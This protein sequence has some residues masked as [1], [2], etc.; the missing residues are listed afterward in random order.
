M[1]CLLSTERPGVHL[2]T[3]QGLGFHLFGIGHGSVYQLLGGMA[4]GDT[5]ELVG[6]SSQT[7]EGVPSCLSVL[8][9]PKTPLQ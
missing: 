7:L 8:P 6:L 3:S 5:A 2:A 4:H 1:S 9:P